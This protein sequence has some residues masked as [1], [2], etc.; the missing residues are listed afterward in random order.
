MGLPVGGEHVHQRRHAIPQGHTVPADPFEPIG[1]I[2]L[3]TDAGNDHGTTGGQ[4]AEEVVDR[5]IEAQ[6]RK[7]EGAILGSHTEA[8]I[9]VQNRIDRAPVLDGHALGAGPWSRR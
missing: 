3:A 6:G 8:L 1:G 5:K 4:Q 9:D 2:P 7:G